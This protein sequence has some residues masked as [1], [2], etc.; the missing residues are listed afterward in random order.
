MKKSTV[1]T[2]NFK[3]FQA[4]A[5]ALK[6]RGA[7]V[8][9]LGL[10]YSDPGLGK[11]FAGIWLADRE[12]AVY[13]RALA[14]M[15]ARWMTEELVRELGAEPRFYMS[16]LYKQARDLLTKEKRLIIIDEIDHLARDR[17]AIETLRDLSD[18]TG[19]SFLLIGMNDC[20]MTLQRIPHLFDRMRAHIVN[21]K[22]LSLDEART[23][24]H[25]LLDVDID[26]RSLTEI[27]KTSGGNFRQLIVNL[28][29]FE[30]QARINA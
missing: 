23:A 9:G 20:L 11:T 27:H 19:A 13:I 4:L 6:A 26:D 5:G 12:E 22:P 28:Y 14:A 2:S 30:R 3:L 17:K 7:G 21:F 29:K 24:A 18:E 25:E 16:H 15:S 10:V 1:A 8:P